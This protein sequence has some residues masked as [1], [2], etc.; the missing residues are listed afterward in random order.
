PLPAMPARPAMAS[1]PAPA[2]PP[3]APPAP[4][5]WPASPVSSV[6]APMP[7]AGAMPAQETPREDGFSQTLAVLHAVERGELTTD[8]ATARLSDREGEERSAQPPA[9]PS[10]EGRGTPCIGPCRCRD[11]QASYK[12]CEAP[13]FAPSLQ[14]GGSG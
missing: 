2:T 8:E 13:S 11:A 12:R 3:P 14:G 7:P 10:L 5:A 6:Q 4:P 9:S 1:R